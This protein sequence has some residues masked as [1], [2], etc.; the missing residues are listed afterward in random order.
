MQWYRYARRPGNLLTEDRDE[1]DPRITEE[2][3]TSQMSTR[4]WDLSRLRERPIAIARDPISYGAKGTKVL[5]SA[6]LRRRQRS[7]T[8]SL[9]PG[10]ID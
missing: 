3:E 7:E 1:A 9:L 6:V 10:Y 4:P 8:R 2:E 5:R